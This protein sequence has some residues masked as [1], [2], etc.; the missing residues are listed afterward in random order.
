V[1]LID[2]DSQGSASA[3]VLAEVSKDEPSMAHV[4]G[5]RATLTDVIRPS[6]IEGVW[7]APATEELTHAQLTIVSKTGRE[8][9]LRRALRSVR[10]Y[11]VAII[12]TAPE[13]H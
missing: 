13:R 6:L 2:M 12:D 10:G 8:S 11:D 3:T 7:V 4:L 9:I 5:G 1:L